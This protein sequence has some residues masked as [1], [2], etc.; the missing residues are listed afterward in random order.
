MQSYHH[1]TAP[2]STPGKGPAAAKKSMPLQSDPS[3]PR[4]TAKSK[5]HSTLTRPQPKP[6]TSGPVSNYDPTPFS[7]TTWT[8]SS[9]DFGLLSEGD[10]VEGREDFVNEYNRTAKKVISYYF[11]LY[12]RWLLTVYLIKYGIRAI[13][14]GDFNPQEVS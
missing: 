14:P 13:V 5:S 9:G 2:I 3:L 10:E 11:M 1:N 12:S 6:S 8:S 4:K 7:S